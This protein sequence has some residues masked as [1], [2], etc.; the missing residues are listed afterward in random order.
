MKS[1]LKKRISNTAETEKH[2]H[3]FYSNYLSKSPQATLFIEGG[4]GVGKTFFIQCL[5]KAAGYTGTVS[6]PTYTLVQEYETDSHSFSHF[7]FYRLK[8]P[9]EFFSRGFQDL[10]QPNRITCI[11]W[12]EKITDDIKHLFAKPTYTIIL[13]HGIGVSMRTLNILTES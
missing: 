12:P 5:L 4:L 6:S 2:A 10:A 11:E 3:F 13:E 8:S 7:D 9:D 1:I